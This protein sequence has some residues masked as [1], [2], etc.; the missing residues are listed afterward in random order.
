MRKGLEVM[1]K[2]TKE[3]TALKKELEQ[4]QDKT[5]VLE[6]TGEAD[7]LKKVEL[8][9]REKFRKQ[10]EENPS[11]LIERSTAFKLSVLL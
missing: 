9:I 10:R 4:Y 8:E 11:T 1:D 6:E 3:N 5:S 2:L 7:K